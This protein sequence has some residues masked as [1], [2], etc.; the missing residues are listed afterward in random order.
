MLLERPGHT[1][2]NLV[3]AHS[4]LRGHGVDGTGD[5]SHELLLGGEIGNGFDLVLR[6]E[7]AFEKA[8]LGLG[9][10]EFLL[11]GLNGLHTGTNIA[12]HQDEGVGSGQQGVEAGPVAVTINGTAHQGVFGHLANAVAGPQTIPQVRHFLDGQAL[13][14]KDKCQFGVGEELFELSDDLLLVLQ[15]AAHRDWI[16]S[17]EQAGHTADRVFERKTRPRADPILNGTKPCRVCL[18]RDY[19]NGN[20]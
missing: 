8:A 20:D 3:D 2:G 17:K 6:Q 5:L 18:G 13:E 10:L 14:I 12:L 7:L 15:R 9:L 1:R 4:D 19:I 16:G 11:E